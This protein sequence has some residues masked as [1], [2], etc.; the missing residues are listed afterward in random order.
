MRDLVFKERNHERHMQHAC[1]F[2]KLLL[3]PKWRCRIEEIKLRLGGFVKRIS[4]EI[5]L[6]ADPSVKKDMALVCA[7]MY[8]MQSQACLPKIRGSLNGAHSIKRLWSHLKAYR[9][10][11]MGT[12]WYEWLKWGLYAADFRR[13]LRDKWPKTQR[14]IA[15]AITAPLWVGR[16]VGRP[17]G[18]YR[19]R[20]LL[21]IKREW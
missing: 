11:L 12:C 15:K 5:F 14:Y 6:E 20:T 13:Q 2:C 9:N 16:S 21:N 4:C 3:T 8:C 7:Q 10:L 17:S 18:G 1:K 19:K